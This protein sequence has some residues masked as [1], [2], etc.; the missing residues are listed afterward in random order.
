MYDHFEREC[1]NAIILIKS[2]KESHPELKESM[3]YYLNI[4]DNKIMLK[5]KRF[6]SKGTLAIEIMNAKN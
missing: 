4:P 6:Y 3:N 5:A 2:L 1:Y